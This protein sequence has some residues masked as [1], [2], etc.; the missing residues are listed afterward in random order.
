[1]FFSLQKQAGPKALDM[2]CP[3]AGCVLTAAFDFTLSIQP[4]AAHPPPQQGKTMPKAKE[5][6]S[7]RI[8]GEKENVF[9]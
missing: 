5:G 2:C 6:H 1:M 4:E 9:L 7:P 3:K 8:S